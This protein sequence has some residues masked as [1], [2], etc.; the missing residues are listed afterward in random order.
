VKTFVNRRLASLAILAVVIAA[1]D[2][3]FQRDRF[4]LDL[5]ALVLVWALAATAWNIV[6]GY[7]N[8][9][10]LGHSAFFAI[11]A[12]TSTLLLVRASISPWIGLWLGA[13]L[14]ALLSAGVAWLCLRLK[15]AYYALATFAL[16]QVVLIIANVWRPITNGAEGLSIPYI[17]NPANFIFDSTNAYIVVFG[18]MLLL[19]IGVTMWMERSRLGLWSLALSS[20][21]E[22]AQALGV[23]VL[24]AKVVGAALS[25]A[26]TAVAGTAYAQY[27]LFI[28]PTSVADIA[29]SIQVAL[30]AVF[31]GVATPFG[32][33]IG[34]A[35]LIPLS[36]FLTSTLSGT[37]A[38]SA[39]GLTFATYGVILIVVFLYLPDGLG[40]RI[41]RLA[42]RAR[43]IIAE[44]G[45][46]AGSHAS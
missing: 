1:Y 17:P 45:A 2:I 32:P 5:G 44:R 11:G 10:A 36:S 31:G 34:A 8:Q 29:F 30:M 15:G 3:G 22:A 19:F 12:Y 18:L 4:F 37:A 33:L 35:I 7:Q 26:L 28:H 21:E 41:M 20:D 46:T 25:G 9:L 14:G 39:P 38:N 40:P 42:G 6:G 16:G 27:L 43:T 24:R 13:I 23:P